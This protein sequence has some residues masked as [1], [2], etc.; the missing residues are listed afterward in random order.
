MVWKEEKES[1]SLTKI[2]WHTKVW[3]VHMCSRKGETQ[4][5]A[6]KRRTILDDWG[7]WRSRSLEFLRSKCCV[8]VCEGE[9]ELGV[10]IER[11]TLQFLMFIER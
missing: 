6:L 10:R 1:S 2:H 3:D 11:G 5:K 9:R 7:T 4:G 8:C